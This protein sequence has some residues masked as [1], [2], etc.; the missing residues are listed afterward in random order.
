[1]LII[2][3]HV[4]SFICEISGTDVQIIPLVDSSICEISGIGVRIIT[5]IDSFIGIFHSLIT[6]FTQILML[7]TVYNSNYSHYAACT[8]TNLGAPYGL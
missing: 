4:D 6:Y 1:M 8:L 7:W 5:L 2:I 3:P